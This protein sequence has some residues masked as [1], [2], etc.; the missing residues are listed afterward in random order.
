MTLQSELTHLA[1]NLRK[2]YSTSNKLSIADMIQLT[3]PPKYPR[4]IEASKFCFTKSGDQ[5]DTT[6]SSGA[7]ITGKC[8]ILPVYYKTSIPAYRTSTLRLHFKV[9]QANSG[10]IQ[11]GLDGLGDMAV[12]NTSE[13]TSDFKVPSSD[14]PQGHALKFYGNNTVIDL[15]Q[16][17]IEIIK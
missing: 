14:N 15:S 16:S 3:E 6:G 4:L 8:Y 11:W 12:W 7:Q 13:A 2:K 5:N 17:Y 1:N 10:T 9:V